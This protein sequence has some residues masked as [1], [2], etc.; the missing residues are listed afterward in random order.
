MA[1]SH[2]RVPLQ[3]ATALAA[4][5]VVVGDSNGGAGPDEVIVEATPGPHRAL[6]RQLLPRAQPRADTRAI[7]HSHVKGR[8]MA[9]V[10]D[11]GRE[12]HIAVAPLS[13]PRPPGRVRA[14]PYCVFLCHTGLQHVT[15]AT[16]A[17]L[18]PM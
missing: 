14:A 15:L 7:T 12:P 4:H 13:P 16:A 11:P 10:L 5:H 1:R 2:V 3:A 9:Q 17:A 8:L 6:T 18:P